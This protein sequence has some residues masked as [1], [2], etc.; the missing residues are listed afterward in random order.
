M[1]HTETEMTILPA[2]LNDGVTVVGLTTIVSRVYVGT[3]P[4]DYLAS[5]RTPW[6]VIPLCRNV[7]Y[8]ASLN[9]LYTKPD[10]LIAFKIHV[11]YKGTLSQLRAEHRTHLTVQHQDQKDEPYTPSPPED[12]V[13]FDLTPG[14]QF[15]IAYQGGITVLIVSVLT[16]GLS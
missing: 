12:N 16:A 1:K 8:P 5:T 11:G 15:V 4:V 14:E 9:M 6:V 3:R 7:P 10:D 13:P 2:D